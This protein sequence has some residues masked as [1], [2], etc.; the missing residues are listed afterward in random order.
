M[1]NGPAESPGMLRKFLGVM[2]ELVQTLAGQEGRMSQGYA[3][4]WFVAGL[5]AQ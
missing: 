1:A 4:T 3:Q 2:S 5:K